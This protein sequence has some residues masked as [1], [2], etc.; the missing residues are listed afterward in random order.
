MENNQ[1]KDFLYAVGLGTQ[2]G[3]LVVLPMIAFLLLGIFLDKKFNTSP[4]FLISLV[5]FS[6]IVTIVDV[7]CLILPFIEKN[8]QK[9]NKN[10]QDK[11]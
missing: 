4:L 10:N 3:L 2:M 1:K 9:N 8:S 7:R 6:I 5:I 11:N